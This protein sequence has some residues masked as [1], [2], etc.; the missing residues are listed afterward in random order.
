MKALQ[1]S[2]FQTG[3]PF[4]RESEGLKTPGY[5]ETVLRTENAAAAMPFFAS[6]IVTVLGLYGAAPTRLP[7]LSMR[8]GV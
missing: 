7:Y 4:R 1:G 5:W 3:S 6:P 2:V 8:I